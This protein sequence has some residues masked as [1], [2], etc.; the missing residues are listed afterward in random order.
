MFSLDIGR[1]YVR[2]YIC[3]LSAADPDAMNQ[4]YEGMTAEALAEFE[5]FGVSRQDVIVTKYAEVRYKG[6]YHE[7][8]MTLDVETVASGNI[9]E[10]AKDFHQ[11]HEALYTFSMPWVPIELRNLR[12]I[13]KLEAK[14]ISLKRIIA[15]PEDPSEALKRKRQCY[16]NGRFMET[17]IYDGAGLKYGNMIP[18]PAV[19]EEPVT[20]LVVPDGFRC[21]I[22]EYGNYIVMGRK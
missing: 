2:S 6:Q 9:E 4:L 10:L 15:G 17:P 3:P 19:V 21:S 16:F 20:T 5:V 22:D 14:K 1:D 7:V 18:G 11:R 13:A 8:E 12:I